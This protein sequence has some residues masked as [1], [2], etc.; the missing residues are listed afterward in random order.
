MGSQQVILSCDDIPKDVVALDFFADWVVKSPSLTNQD[1][2]PFGVYKYG[3]KSN[4]ARYLHD[5]I[6]NGRLMRRYFFTR[7]EPPSKKNAPRP[8]GAFM[9]TFTDPD[10]TDQ[11][12]VPYLVAQ[13]GPDTYLT[14]K[15][16]MANA[17]SVVV[18]KTLDP[19]LVV[20]GLVV[21]A[22]TM[23]GVVQRTGRDILNFLHL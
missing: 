7:D 5:L 6:D 11:S 4:D 22:D 12:S 17:K 9:L 15:G 18:N 14:F 10:N 23:A 8:T 20:L 19:V 3:S 1:L 2:A 13:G 16:L 21:L